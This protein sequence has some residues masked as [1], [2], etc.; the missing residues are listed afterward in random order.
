M[1]KLSV[2]KSQQYPAFKLYC[3]QHSAAV[4]RERPDLLDTPTPIFTVNVQCITSLSCGW[5]SPILSVGLVPA[6][7]TAKWGSA[8]IAKKPFAKPKEMLCRPVKILLDR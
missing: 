5:D 7:G 1:S 2:L 6:P 3:R 8:S 4:G